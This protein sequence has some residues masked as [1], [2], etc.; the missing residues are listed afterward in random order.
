MMSLLDRLGPVWLLG[1]FF[2]GHFASVAMVGLVLEKRGLSQVVQLVWLPTMFWPVPFGTVQNFLGTLFGRL[3]VEHR[4]KARCLVTYVKPL[5][6]T[7]SSSGEFTN[8]T[9]QCRLGFMSVM[10]IT[11]ILK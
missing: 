10:A 5:T 11:V 3:H 8:M 4:C 2:F 7:T 9:T 6:V 1:R